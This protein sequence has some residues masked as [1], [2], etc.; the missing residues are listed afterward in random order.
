VPNFFPDALKFVAPYR[1]GGRM[2]T[3]GILRPS[4]SA[5]HRLGGGREDP[6]QVDRRIDVSQAQFST[7]LVLDELPNKGRRHSFYSMGLKL[8]C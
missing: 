8:S 7:Q 2:R 6:G 1:P 4:V 3:T 5:E